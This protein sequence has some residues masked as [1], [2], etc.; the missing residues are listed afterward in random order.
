MKNEIEAYAF[1][2]GPEYGFPFT[3][4]GKKF[5]NAMCAMP[6]DKYIGVT[7]KL[8]EGITVTCRTKEEAEKVRTELQNNEVWNL[9]DIRP[10]YVDK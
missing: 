2:V 9:G 8:P 4:Q 10:C 6:K 1:T 7:A 3:I 5:I